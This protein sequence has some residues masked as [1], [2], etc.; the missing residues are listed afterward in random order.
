[1]LE[2]PVQDILAIEEFFTLKPV[3]ANI[4]TYYGNGRHH[5]IWPIHALNHGKAD[6]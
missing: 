2:I 3:N 5:A 6:G 1:M 4:T